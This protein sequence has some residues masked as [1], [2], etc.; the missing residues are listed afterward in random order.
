MLELIRKQF[1]VSAEIFHDPDCMLMVHLNSMPPEQY[2]V[3][4]RINI[5]LIRWAYG[6]GN[7]LLLNGKLY[8]G[9]RRAAGEMGHTIVDPNGPLCICGNKGCL[10]VYAS[11]RSILEKAY[12]ARDTGRFN[13]AQY[14]AGPDGQMTRETIWAAYQQMDECIVP[15]VN[16]AVDYMV[17]A[18]VNIV[19]FLDPAM[20]ILEGEF[21]T[22]PLKCLDRLK[23][24][25]LSR[26]QGNQL[27]EM[28]VQPWEDSGARGAAEMLMTT[29]FSLILGEDEG[30]S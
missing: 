18:V 1:G 15:I 5:V 26:L 21:A 13:S 20:I 14:P 22:A 4:N 12:A 30:V 11:F 23:T 7:A 9:D 8:Y 6:I 27:V 2:A 10:E 19:Q 29:V 25:V 28:Q 17:S 3:M 16:S 24:G